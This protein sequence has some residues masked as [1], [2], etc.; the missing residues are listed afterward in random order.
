MFYSANQIINNPEIKPIFL[1]A[2]Y[3]FTELI[4]NFDFIHNSLLEGEDF[5]TESIET[6]RLV[7]QYLNN[8][9]D[10]QGIKGKMR[11]ALN[12]NKMSD[13]QLISKSNSVQS[14]N[15]I[16]DFSSLLSK[17]LSAGFIVGGT[18]AIIHFI[19]E[20]MKDFAATQYLQGFNDGKKYMLKK[21]LIILAIVSVILVLAYVIYKIYKK[22]KGLSNEENSIVNESISNLEKSKS[23]LE[24]E[25]NSYLVGKVDKAIEQLKSV[26]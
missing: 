9:E 4:E 17:L 2:D 19:K 7:S 21:V 20:G 12:L 18:A 6:D 14:F 3:K 23:T 8:G 25:D 1:N 10:F 11:K 13:N 26:Q 22:K 15:L 24:Q 5:L 16:D